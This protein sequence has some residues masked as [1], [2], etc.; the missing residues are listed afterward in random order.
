MSDQIDPTT[1]TPA[2]DARQPWV[3]PTC[4]EYVVEALTQFGGPGRF[5]GIQFS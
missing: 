4:T 1:A 2:D 3:E 5:D